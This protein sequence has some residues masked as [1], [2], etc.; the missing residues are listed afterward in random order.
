MMIRMKERQGGEHSP[1]MVA[2]RLLRP[3]RCGG[4]SLGSVQSIRDARIDEQGG[5][6]R[7]NRTLIGG[8]VVFEV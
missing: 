5:E 8:S 6:L 1:A 3:G 2:C 4:E 7:K